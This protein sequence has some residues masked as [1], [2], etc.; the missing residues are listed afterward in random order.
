MPDPTRPL[1]VIALAPAAGPASAATI[2][3]WRME[4]DLDADP[5][6]LEVAN[7][8]AFGTSLPELATSVAATVKGQTEISVGNVL[9]SNVF[10]LGLIGAKAWDA[11][12]PL[13]QRERGGGRA[14]RRGRMTAAADI[15]IVGGGL[16]GC[17]AALQLARRGRAVLPRRLPDQLLERRGAAGDLVD[18]RR[19]RVAA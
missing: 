8:V 11:S 2:G 15:R 3:Y 17:E 18:V 9:G 14:I 4:A 10:N 16:A 5:D 6:G 7:E 19:V 1:A 12:K 13:P